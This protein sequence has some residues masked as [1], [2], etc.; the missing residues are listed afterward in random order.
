MPGNRAKAAGVFESGKTWSY[1]IK[2]IV[3]CQQ[4]KA[5]STFK[6]V[7]ARTGGNKRLAAVSLRCPF[8]CFSFVRGRALFL[9]ISGYFGPLSFFC[10]MHMRLRTSMMP[11]AHTG[12]IVQVLLRSRRFETCRRDRFDD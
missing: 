8:C 3:D 2:S 5:S 4:M 7:I 9:F 10:M 1:H 12:F 11:D 6:I